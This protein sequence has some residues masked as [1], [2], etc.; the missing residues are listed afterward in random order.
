MLHTGKNSDC[1]LIGMQLNLI[2]IA[3]ERPY[4]CELCGKGFRDHN[5]LTKHNLV[6]SDVRAFACD[7]CGKKFKELC[8]LNKH[9][10]VH[11]SKKSNIKI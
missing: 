5:A 9:K 7:K 3:G 4:C 11:S 1:Y 2:F 6:H 10:V 8:N